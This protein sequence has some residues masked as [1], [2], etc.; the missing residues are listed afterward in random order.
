M[1]CNFRL[2]FKLQPGLK[3]NLTNAVSPSSQPPYAL[4]VPEAMYNS[5]NKINLQDDVPRH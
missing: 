3:L 1:L 5:K 4:R 2:Y